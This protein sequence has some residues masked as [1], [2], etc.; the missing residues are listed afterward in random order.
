MSESVKSLNRK[1]GGGDIVYLSID[2]MK[3][4]TVHYLIRF[5]PN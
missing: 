4:A 3:G 1:S 5:E 2:A